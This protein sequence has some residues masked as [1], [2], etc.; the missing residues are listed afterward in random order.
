M[1][2]GLY[3]FHVTR[4]FFC[5]YVCV[6]PA[7]SAH[8]GWKRWKDPLELEL[9]PLCSTKRVLG[10]QPEPS[11]KQHVLLSTEPSLQSQ[12][13]FI[14]PNFLLICENVC[15]FF[16]TFLCLGF[17]TSKV[18][19]RFSKTDSKLRIHS[20]TLWELKGGAACSELLWKVATLESHQDCAVE[21]VT[22]NTK[23][24]RGM[25]GTKFA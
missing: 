13:T 6:P 2:K 23:Q 4:A 14:F 16:L 22:L 3:L 21:H 7:C 25:L 10:T 15:E 12:R 24:V 1:F 5:I 18:V 11:A 9:L 20:V 17:S 8:Q 19:G